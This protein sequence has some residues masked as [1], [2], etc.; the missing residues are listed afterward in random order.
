MLVEMGQESLKKNL[1]GGQRDKIDT[2]KKT[3]KESNLQEPE[4]KMNIH[5]EK[6]NVGASSTSKEKS[7]EGTFLGEGQKNTTKMKSTQFIWILKL[8]E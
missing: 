8:V 5:A 1:S 4:R 7:T 2:G 6:S 3:E